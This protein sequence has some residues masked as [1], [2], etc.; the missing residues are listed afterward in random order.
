M[1]HIKQFQRLG[2]NINSDKYLLPDGYTPIEQPYYQGAGVLY[3]GIQQEQEECRPSKV[4]NTSD[5]VVVVGL[6]GHE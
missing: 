2:M 4:T 3:G 5:R 6:Q 1:S